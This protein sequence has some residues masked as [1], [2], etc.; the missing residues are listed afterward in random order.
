MAEPLALGIDIGGTGVKL[1]LVDRNGR[2]S[3]LRKMPT[4]K[5]VPAIQAAEAI[6]E[7]ASK[8]VGAVQAS[9]LTGVGV[10]VAG[11]I[12][13]QAGVVRMSPNLGWRQVPIRRLLANALGRPVL[14]ENDANVAAWAAFRVEAKA[15]VRNLLCVTLGTGIGGGIV[16]DG[17]LYRGATGTAG[18]IGHTT[19]D[20][21]GHPCACGNRGCLE[22]YVGAR[23][24]SEEARRAIKGGEKSQIAKLVKGDLSKI[25]PL[26]VQRAAR[27]GDRL[28]KRL[29]KDA[30]ERLGISLASMVNVLNPDWIVLSGGLSRAGG[31][32][33][34]PVRR[35]I[36]ERSFQAPARAVKL[37]ISRLDQDLGTVGAALLAHDS[38]N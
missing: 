32:L 2:I 11:D 28:A 35:M 33:L 22:R 36:K 10:G 14:V 15:R 12:D 23:A 6:A 3:S 30:G 1:G 19:L 9:R 18:E 8:L 31:L 20:P 7:E 17:R 34:D 27:Q 21:N 37:V 16:V 29:W 24:M 38:F 13:S 4:P 5:G 26:I 25:E